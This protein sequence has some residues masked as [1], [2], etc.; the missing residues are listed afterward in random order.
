M[1]SLAF[2]FWW[3]HFCEHHIV[4]NVGSRWRVSRTFGG[5]LFGLIA[6]LCPSLIC[7]FLDFATLF[8]VCVSCWRGECCDQE[9]VLRN[10]FQKILHIYLRVLVRVH[11]QQATL[12]CEV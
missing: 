7:V 8:E 10:A 3:I 9:L 11:T 6:G 5:E 4:N 2:L 1:L 12:L